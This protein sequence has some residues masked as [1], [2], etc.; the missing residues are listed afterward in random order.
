MPQT[1]NEL[2]F[3]AAEYGQFNLAY[4]LY[5]ATQQNLINMTDPVDTIDF[6]KFPHEAI[7]HALKNDTLGLIANSIKLLLLKRSDGDWAVYLA[8]SEQE[9]ADLHL[10]IFGEKPLQVV[11]NTDKMDSSVWDD[12]RKKYISFR[13]I[14]KRMAAFPSFLFLMD[15]KKRKKA[16]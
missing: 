3:E 10:K 6:D 9:A 7:Q 16:A 13:E 11:N 12:E 4:A 14:K 8:K 2:F 5:I 1:V 15:S